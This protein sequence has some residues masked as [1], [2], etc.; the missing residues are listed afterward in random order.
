MP[1][2]HGIGD[3]NEDDPIKV[4]AEFVKTAVV[5]LKKDPD[6]GS[7]VKDVFDDLNE[8]FSGQEFAGTFIPPVMQMLGSFLSGGYFLSPETALKLMKSVRINS[9]HFY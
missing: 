1:F 5:Q 8:A 7:K 9:K 6:F 3:N 2:T 4:I